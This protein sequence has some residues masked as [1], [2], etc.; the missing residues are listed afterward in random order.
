MHILKAVYDR[1]CET[2]DFTVRVHVSCV[3]MHYPGVSN[4][5]PHRMLGCVVTGAEDSYHRSH[6]LGKPV[7]SIS[8]HQTTPT[9]YSTGKDQSKSVD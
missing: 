7:S 5:L 2:A 9:G 8:R 4:I 3:D 6:D 1:L